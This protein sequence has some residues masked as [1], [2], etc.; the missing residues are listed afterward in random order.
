MR[1]GIFD[2]RPLVHTSD[3]AT[4]GLD[5]AE[6]ERLSPLLWRPHEGLSFD[7]VVGA[8]ESAEFLRQSRTVADTWGSQGVATRFE[9]ISG[10]DH[11]TIV[12]PLA[13]PASAMT[14]RLADLAFA[15]PS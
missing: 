9:A 7:A 10:A 5:A 8:G 4:L 15:R 3:A 13:D 12:A 2:L 6:A 11:F 14:K 1:S